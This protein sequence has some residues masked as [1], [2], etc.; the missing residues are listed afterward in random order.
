MVVV[1]RKIKRQREREGGSESLL[2]SVVGQKQ[3]RVGRTGG[4][5]DGQGLG[6]VNISVSAPLSREG[7][8]RDWHQDD[9]PREEEE[10]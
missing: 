1:G 5:T 4:R 3:A 7:G 10:D 2:C 9:A 8:R 6:P